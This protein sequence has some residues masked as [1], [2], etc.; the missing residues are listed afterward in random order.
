MACICHSC[1]SDQAHSGE[2]ERTWGLK[3]EDSR[4][5]AFVERVPMARCA[6]DV[7]HA[8]CLGGATGSFC[9]TSF[10]GPESAFLS[11][12]P[13]VLVSSAIPLRLHTE[14]RLCVGIFRALSG[15]SSNFCIS[16]TP[17]G[18]LVVAVGNFPSNE[19]KKRFR[20]CSSSKFSG[21]VA[22]RSVQ[23]SARGARG[24]AV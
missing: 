9:L 1:A 22:P 7:V 2:E 11:Y 19:A 15:A 17:K 8:M 16:C 12:L 4:E 20:K 5:Y 10:A 21:R 23:E 14:T 18:I 6:R 3:G 13:Q 24:D